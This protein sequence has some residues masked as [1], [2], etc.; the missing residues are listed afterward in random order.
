MS[1][2]D[3]QNQARLKNL[4][5]TL[6]EGFVVTT[7]W[8]E[9]HG[10]TRQL[11]SNYVASGW[12]ERLLQG[13]YQRPLSGMERQTPD[14]RAA[15]LSAQRLMHHAFHVG[16]LTALD[17]QGHI[18]Y[19]RLAATTPVYLY[20]EDVPNWLLKLPLET[21]VVR[22]QASL[23]KDPRLGV[24]N[25]SINTWD[26]GE[27]MLQM[28]RWEITMSTPER[29]IF[30]T[31]NEAPRDESFHNIDVL[32][33]SLVNL[34]P[35]LLTELLETCFSIKAKRLFM[36]YADKHDHA[37]RKHLDLSKVNFGTGDRALTEGGKLH[38]LYRI[39]VPAELM[40]QDGSDG[41]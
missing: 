10:V 28:R 26:G 13:L 33:E 3:G 22:R 37:W 4:L 18:H 5:Q 6:P 20:G 38:P 41:P 2:M 1:T 17:L 35:K 30:E 7:A 16:G 23:F 8:L 29:A 21:T 36:I 24:A 27:V 40:P 11:A 9:E 14:W 19:L 32:F 15:V 31:I 34:R 39:T 12:L 25:L